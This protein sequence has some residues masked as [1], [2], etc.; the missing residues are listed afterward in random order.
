MGTNKIFYLLEDIWK[1]FKLEPLALESLDSAG[2]QQ[3]LVRP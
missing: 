3:S 1:M 2:R